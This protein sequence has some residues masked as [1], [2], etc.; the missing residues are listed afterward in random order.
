MR[1]YRPSPATCIA[2]LA[3][4]I[5]L[6]GTTYAVTSLP[7]G[8]VGTPQLRARAV[9]EEKLA[10]DAIVTRK[11]ANGAVRAAKIAPASISGSRIAPDAIGGEQVDEAAL[12]TVPRAQQSDRAALAVRAAV[13]DRVEHIDRVARADSAAQAD[14]ATHAEDAERSRVADSVAAVDTNT[15]TVVVQPSDPA[16]LSVACDAGLVPVGGGLRQ[17]AG[18]GFVQILDSGPLA[19]GWA[20]TVFNLSSTDTITVVVSAICMRAGRT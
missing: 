20:A 13:A 7:R 8:S 16:V 19:D 6:G 5:S 9:T 2:T 4:F 10:N 3:L 18:D 17:T 11:L 12:A 1:R 14:R 15:E